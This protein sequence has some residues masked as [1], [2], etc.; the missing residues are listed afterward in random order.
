MG[1]GKTRLEGRGVNNQCQHR[2]WYY[3]DGKQS[4]HRLTQLFILPIEYVSANIADQGAFG[5]F[6]ISLGEHA[7]KEIGSFHN[8]FAYM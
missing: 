1:K 6:K 4:F 8:G 2:R 7:Q 3:V 5:S